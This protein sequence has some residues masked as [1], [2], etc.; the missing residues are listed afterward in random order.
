MRRAAGRLA[1]RDR[2]AARAGDCRCGSRGSDDAE[3]VLADRVGCRSRQAVRGPSRRRVK[4]PAGRRS[5]LACSRESVGWAKKRRKP[6]RRW[7]NRG[8]GGGLPLGGAPVEGRRS[9][10]GKPI[11]LTRERWKRLWHRGSLGRPGASRGDRERQRSVPRARARSKT[12]RRERV[13]NDAAS[14]R[15]GGGAVRTGRSWVG[16]RRAPTHPESE[17]RKAV[18][19]PASRGRPG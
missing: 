16:R 8:I 12:P 6:G 10:S 4:S 18:R 17:G 14:T 9:E 5:G 7:Q 11:A 1:E 2:R 3:I 15:E 19:T 13:G